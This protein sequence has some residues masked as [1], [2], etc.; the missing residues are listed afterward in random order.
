MIKVFICGNIVFSKLRNKKQ[1]KQ[2]IAPL[3]Q[4]AIGTTQSENDNLN[5]QTIT[6]ISRCVPCFKSVIGISW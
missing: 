2:R 6:Y 4:I 3:V 5:L 1:K